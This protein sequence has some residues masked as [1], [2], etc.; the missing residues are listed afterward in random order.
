[1]RAGDD[2]HQPVVAA[3]TLSKKIKARIS[4]RKADWED[5]RTER[6]SFNTECFILD[7]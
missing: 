6:K 5:A 7:F 3:L 1:M 2:F 4:R